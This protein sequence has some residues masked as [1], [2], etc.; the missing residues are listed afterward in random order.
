MKEVRLRFGHF[1][2][3]IGHI[4]T[5]ATVRDIMVRGD[6]PFDPKP[7]SGTQRTYDGADLLRWKG[8]EELRNAGLKMHHAAKLMRHSGAVE[9]FFEAM[10][11]GEDVD[12]FYLYFAQE[13]P[14]EN[15]GWHEL[16]YEFCRGV[17]LAAFLENAARKAP[18]IRHSVMVPLMPI[19]RRAQE[20]AASLGFQLQ[21]DTLFLDVKAIRGER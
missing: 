9:E 2:E 16:H 13:Y 15:G 4:E 12:G 7:K 11:K 19:Y 8:F 1:C 17:D 21:R 5:K 14:K 18:A 6:P 3:L 20:Q 10:E